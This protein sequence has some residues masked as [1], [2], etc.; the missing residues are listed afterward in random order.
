MLN[1]KGDLLSSLGTKTTSVEGSDGNSVSTQQAINVESTNR[2]DNLLNLVGGQKTSAAATEEVNSTDTSKTAKTSTKETAGD[3]NSAVVVKD[4]DS[5]SKESALNEV[6]KL[7]EENKAYRL[8]YA[9]SLDKLK[10]EAQLKIEAREQEIQELLKSKEE[11]EL[12]KASEADKKRSIEEKLAH[13]EALVAELKTKMDMV[14]NQYKGELSK[15]EQ[16]LERF[17]ADI[18]AQNQV[19]KER[20]H[21]EISSIPEKFKDVAELIIRGAGDNREALIAISEAK[22]KGVFDDKTVIVNHSVPGANNGARSTQEKLEAAARELSDK[23]TPQQKI[24]AALS[25][26]KGGT[27]NSAFRK[28]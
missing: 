13:R 20:L 15:R 17:R 18:E 7:R 23:M 27:P 16:E 4:P 9:E 14:E 2:G 1:N 26:I 11:L 22:L 6:K 25:Q 8:K 10:S 19:Y 28:N 3:E 21:N 12:R 5:W 24:K